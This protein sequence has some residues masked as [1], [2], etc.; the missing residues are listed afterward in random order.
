M[1]M[2]FSDSSA[3]GQK[4]WEK[5]SYNEWS[6][7]DA[8]RVLTDSPWAQ[9]D[10]EREPN[11]YTVIIRLRSAL[12][13]RQAIV[14]QR[15]I[16]L[17]YDKFTPADK[18]RFDA[19]VKEFIEC[20]DCSKYYILT[21]GTM[22]DSYPLR[23]LKDISLDAL[24]SYT[25][26]TNDKG[27]RRDL[28]HFIPPKSEGGDAMFVFERFDNKGKPLLTASNKKFYFKI[29]EKVFEGKTLPIK[30]FTFEVSKLLRNGEI[31]F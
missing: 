26:L 6:M 14:R 16:R 10:I 8:L 17:N 27:E 24:K 29:D 15:Q 18:S 20:P 12:P 2:L 4:V 19:E 1:A 7:S 3:Y 5:K 22:N 23:A 28:V 21:L 11:G 31:I 25:S 9:T 30:K 13:V